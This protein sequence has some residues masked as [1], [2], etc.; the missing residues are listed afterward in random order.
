MRVLHLAASAL[1]LASSIYGQIVCHTPSEG[2]GVSYSVNIPEHTASN[3]TGPMYL[4]LKAP[5]DLKWFALGQGVQMTDGNLFVVYAG[6]DG[7]VTLSPRKATG[8]IEP[9]Y[10]SSIHATLLEGSG[11]RHG[12]MI[13]NIRCDN[14]MTLNDG[15]S[16]MGNSN[17]SSWIWAM[18]GGGPMNSANVSAQIYKHDWHGIFTL[19]LSHGIGANSPNPFF[20]SS[21]DIMDFTP[22]SVQQQVSDTILH[23]KR[24]AHGVMTS[25]AFVLLFPNFGLTL[26]I[27]PSRYTVAWIH[28][29]LQIFAVLLALA[30]FAVGV[31]AAIDLREEAGYHPVLGYVAM[32]G[33]VLV[34][35]VLGIVQHVRFRRTGKKTAYGVAHR[36]LG[37]FLSV[38]GIVNGGIGF[39]Y[40]ASM[41]PDIPPASPIAYG[42]ISG[43]MGVIYILVIWWR[44]SKTKREA[45]L[46]VEAADEKLA[47]SAAPTRSNSTLVPKTPGVDVSKE[48]HGSHDCDTE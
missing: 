20:S 4:Q 33:V 41:N 8:P 29:P 35:P 7:N 3:G 6:P 36:W 22:F 25:V 39:H 28:A 47:A 12:L 37:R 2:K 1:C 18:T 45:A 23:R 30:G 10:N 31:S 5:A 38:L 48:K 17:L 32:A 11:I 14:C 43:S 19:D 16:I 26:H 13:A 46:N 40:A 15:T 27:F 44:R 9:L 21:H 34:Q 24:I 42:I